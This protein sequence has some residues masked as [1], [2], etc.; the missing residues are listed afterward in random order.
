MRIVAL[1][2]AV[3]VMA[4]FLAVG[5]PKAYAQETQITDKKPVIV[6]VRK[7]DSLS[8][9]AS[10]HGTTYPRLFN[11]NLNVEHPDLI[12]PDEK[13]RIPL[14]DEQLKERPLPGTAPAPAIVKAKKSKS[15]SVSKHAKSAPKKHSYRK[16]AKTY[17]APKS[18][19]K[20]SVWDKLAACESSGNW[21]IN[22]GNGY[23]GG[24]QFTLSSW[25]AVGGQG[26]PHLASKA[27]Q[28]ARAEKLKAI[29]GWG[30][31]PACTSKLGLR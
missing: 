7:G 5:S 31:W 20:G 6:T 1:G 11:A 8:K 22:T 16:P 3:F 17:S 9:I 2:A 18:T 25:R 24:L 27:E 26:Y 21:S 4:A 12:F 15:A 14:A 10:R 28:I 29:Q 23:Y 19:V 30:A 13:L